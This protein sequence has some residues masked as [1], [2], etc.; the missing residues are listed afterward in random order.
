MKISVIFNELLNENK[1]K[2]ILKSKSDKG[3]RY[4]DILRTGLFHHYDSPKGVLI[5]IGGGEK[6]R[7]H[8]ISKLSQE[9]KKTYRAWIKTPE[10][11]E[12]LSIWN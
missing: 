6:T 3:N 8:L 9:D 4:F 11:E 10:G 12:S 7:K 5:P 1:D 2:I